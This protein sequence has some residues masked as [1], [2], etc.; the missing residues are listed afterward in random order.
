MSRVPWRTFA[1][2]RLGF[3]MVDIR[4]P[5]END[6]RHS[7]I[8]LSRAGIPGHMSNHDFGRS[9]LSSGL[10]ARFAAPSVSSPDCSWITDHLTYNSV[11]VN[12]K[13]EAPANTLSGRVLK[14]V[15]STST[16]LHGTWPECLGC[17]C[18]PFV[19]GHQTSSQSPAK[20]IG[21]IIAEP[22]RPP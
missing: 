12:L 7:T 1:R 10:M 20:V 2:C 14:P 3:G 19:F 4:P 5:I 22:C 11:P 13:S 8:D 9:H 17:T 18:P 15:T 21:S 6:G 16:L